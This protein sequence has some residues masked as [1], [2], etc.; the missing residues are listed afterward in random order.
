MMSEERMTRINLEPSPK[1][2]AT[3]IKIRY[4]ITGINSG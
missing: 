2:K 4:T 1:I 3:A